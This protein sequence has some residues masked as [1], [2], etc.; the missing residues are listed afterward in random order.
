MQGLE[1]EYKYDMMKMQYVLV[2]RID[3]SLVPKKYQPA[4]IHINHLPN[5]TQRIAAISGIVGII[6][7]ITPEP[8]IKDAKDKEE[9]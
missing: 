4:M 7:G 8:E 2:V 3:S 6:E 1:Y 9:G 5:I